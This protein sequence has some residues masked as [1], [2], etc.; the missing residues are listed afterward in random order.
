MSQI[1]VFC[2]VFFVRC[3]FSPQLAMA[4]SEFLG[5]LFILIPCLTHTYS[6]LSPI[7]G[8][9]FRVARCPNINVTSRSFRK[10]HHKWD[11]F[12]F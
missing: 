6:I 12:L 11:I 1:N 5:W 2:F 4:G 8:R 7:V 3:L 10:S 9:W